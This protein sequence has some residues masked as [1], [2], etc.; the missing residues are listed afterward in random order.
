M[1]SMTSGDRLAMLRE[2]LFTCT[3]VDRVSAVKPGGDEP[4]ASDMGGRRSSGRTLS[5]S[6]AADLDLARSTCPSRT[7]SVSGRSC[8][9]TRCGGLTIFRSSFTVYI[10]ILCEPTICLAG[11]GCRKSWEIFQS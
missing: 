11:L 8:H 4:W 10:A 3:A 6:S 2:K 5:M 1:F 9:R 7:R